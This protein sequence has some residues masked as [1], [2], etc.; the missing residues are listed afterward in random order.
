MERTLRNTVKALSSVE[1][2][3]SSLIESLALDLQLTSD[4]NAL[5]NSFKQN[6]QGTSEEVRSYVFRKQQEGKTIMLEGGH[7]IVEM[8]EVVIRGM[9]DEESVKHRLLD[10]FQEGKI[11]SF[12]QLRQVVGSELIRHRGTTGDQP[13]EQVNYTT[14][15]FK[16]PHQQPQPSTTRQQD[17]RWQPDQRRRPKYAT[18]YNV[19]NL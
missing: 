1:V 19:P 14:G 12:E 16:T 15:T 5:I 2:T 3:V 10:K 4:P 6:S 11:R 13:L 7:N 18:I 8:V 17:K 9:R